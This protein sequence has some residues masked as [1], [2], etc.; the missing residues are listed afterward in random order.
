[1]VW[2]YPQCCLLSSD[3]LRRAKIKGKQVK[4]INT[5]LK[6]YEESKWVML[7]LSNSSKVRF[8]CIAANKWKGL[9]VFSSLTV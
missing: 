4:K 6:Y 9:V 8:R 3:E 5:K 7:K 2:L 1:M